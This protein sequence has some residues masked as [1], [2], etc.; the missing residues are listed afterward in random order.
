MARIRFNITAALTRWRLREAASPQR[1]RM[2]DLQAL[3]ERPRGPG[4]FDSSW[5]LD[6][7]LVVEVA[8][9]GDPPFLAWIEAQARAIA[10]STAQPAPPSRGGT[11]VEGMLEFEPVDWRAWAPP[12]ESIDASAKARP[13]GLDMPELELELVGLE[14]DCAPV[15]ELELALV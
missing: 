4:W 15:T 5:D 1:F 13:A 14:L 8:V 12:Q 11:P 9:P 10:Q 2:M 3:H 7:G 6:H